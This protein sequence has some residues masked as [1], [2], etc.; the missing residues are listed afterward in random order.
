MPTVHKE[1][2]REEFE[3]GSVVA[4]GSGRAWRSEKRGSSRQPGLRSTVSPAVGAG[5]ELG[6]CRSMT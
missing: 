1:S 5:D 6:R 4:F 2:L 3:P